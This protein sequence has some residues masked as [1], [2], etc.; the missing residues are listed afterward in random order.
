[1]LFLCLEVSVFVD[2]VA[3]EKDFG[4]LLLLRWFLVRV[5]SKDMCLAAETRCGFEWN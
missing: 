2:G 4:L 1:M 3:K 5:R